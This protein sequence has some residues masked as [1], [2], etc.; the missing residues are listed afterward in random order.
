M[1]DL[2]ELYLLAKT[3]GNTDA[4]AQNT[5]LASAPEYVKDAAFIAQGLFSQKMSQ[6]RPTRGYFRGLNAVRLGA[7]VIIVGLLALGLPDGAGGPIVLAIFW[8]LIWAV[9][10]LANIFA[11]DSEYR[12]QV[13][14][15][16]LQEA[17]AIVTE[18]LAKE[19]AVRNAMFDA[20]VRG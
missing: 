19:E 5:A 2:L 3:A 17:W 11:R 6:P 14:N 10:E 16:A 8:G 18:K 4:I 13:K 12:Q 15:E 1:S 20:A 9:M 7:G